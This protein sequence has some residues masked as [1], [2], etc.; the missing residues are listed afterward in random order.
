[1]KFKYKKYS[2]EIIRPIIPIDLVYKNSPPITYEVLVDSG[3]DIC[4]FD[5]EIG[6]L[7]GINLEKGE[8]KEVGGITG[9]SETYYIHPITIKVGGWP[10]NIKAGFLRNIAKLGYGVVG[11]KGF[12]DLFSVKFDYFKQEIELKEKNRK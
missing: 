6:E 4:I 10:Y 9:V 12:F 7:L 8:K 2:S 11:Q 1:M 3:A 5:A